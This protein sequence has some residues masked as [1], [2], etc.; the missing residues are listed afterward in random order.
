MYGGM[1]LYKDGYTEKAAQIIS[2]MLE[3]AERLGHSFVGSEHLILAMLADGK[4][5][6]AAILRANRVHL[7][8]F[9]QA[10]LREIGSGEPV[11]LTDSAY[12]PA[13]RRILRYAE[14]KCPT[15]M[16]VSSEHLL[17]AVLTEEQC[18]A[19]AIFR[20][21]GISLHTLRASCGRQSVPERILDDAVRFDPKSCPNLCKYAADLTDPASA[22]KFDPLIGRESEVEQVMQILLRRTKNN[23]VLIGQAGVGK[24]AI[25][26]GIAQRILSGDV[27]PMLENRILLSLDLAALLAG[28]RYRGDFEERLKAC[29][30]EA[31][32][33]PQIILFID[34][35]HTIAGAGAAEGAMDAANVLKPRLARGELHLIGEYRRHI[36]KDAALE[37][38]FQPVYIAE[39]S[40]ADAVRMLEGLRPH[41]EAFHRLKIGADA[42]GAAVQYS[43]RYLHDRALPD[44]ALDLLDEACAA[45]KLRVS[46]AADAETAQEL[47]GIHAAEIEQLISVKTGIPAQTLT[48]SESEKLLRLED[49]MRTRIVGQDEAITAVANAVRRSRAGLRGRGRPV[50]SFLFLGAT[51]VGKTALA[52]CIADV[53]FDGSCIRTDMSEYTEK[54]NAARLIGAPPGYLGYDDGNSLV[55]RVR[56]HPYSLILFDEIE[57]AHP[58][59]LTLLLQI[60]EDGTL[61]DGQGRKAD[62]SETMVILTSNLGAEQLKSA[63][64]GFS[65]ADSDDAERRER[66]LTH[67]RTIMRPE[68]LNRLDEITVFRQMDESDHLRVAE[69][70][71]CALAN[72]SA[73]ADCELTWTEEAVKW[74]V[75]QSDTKHG[76]ARA[77]RTAVAKYAEPLLA[78][79]ILRHGAGA[80]RL[81]VRTGKLIAESS[82][83]TPAAL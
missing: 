57:K 42:I 8:R 17:A 26:E 45:K 63:G 50:G 23:P 64:I 7:Q 58:D 28:A 5:V 25:V 31:S 80:F 6:G 67:L 38:R 13:L 14:Q 12:T 30:D 41:Y 15:D 36:E 73:A 19:A 4:N 16:R 10:V 72:R 69:Q 33:E 77:I 43:V 47:I 24:T 37:R 2:N 53:L 40:Q 82:A 29:I 9:E 56:K 71:L 75:R 51:G 27:P 68:L 11:A 66:L 61:T 18:G 32:S 20:G 81:G 44:K 74:I 3:H 54:H 79:H 78:D 59:I 62:F 46:R 70:Q 55:E 21:M 22:A 83:D 35:L 65:E 34:E 48:E 1:S 52:Q 49:T 60:L 76:S 39:P